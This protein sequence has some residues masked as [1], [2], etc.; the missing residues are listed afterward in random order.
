[1]GQALESLCDLVRLFVS[2]SVSCGDVTAQ[3]HEQ[4]TPGISFMDDLCLS[5]SQRNS[6]VPKPIAS[7]KPVLI[8]YLCLQGNI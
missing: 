6:L 2:E 5:D 3:L 4:V 1:M 8:C 7:H